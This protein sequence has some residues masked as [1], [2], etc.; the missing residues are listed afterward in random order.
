MAAD[1]NHPLPAFGS[2]HPSRLLRKLVDHMKGG[3]LLHALRLRRGFFRDTSANLRSDEPD[4]NMMKAS[5]YLEICVENALD[6]YTVEDAL[7][8]HNEIIT[9]LS[10][11]LNLI[12]AR[13]WPQTVKSNMMAALED[14]LNQHAE[15]V[16]RLAAVLESNETFK[17]QP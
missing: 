14:R 3:A 9:E 1:G 16:A 2:T 8:W 17:W 10:I 6:A 13:R 7:Y 5:E 11:E 4:A 15:A 12:H